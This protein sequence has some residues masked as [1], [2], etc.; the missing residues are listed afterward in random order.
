VTRLRSDSAWAE[1]PEGQGPRAGPRA[2]CRRNRTNMDAALT[3]R[4]VIA[5][6]TR[7]R[8][9]TGL[10]HGRAGS[11]GP[12]PPARLGGAGRRP[13]AF[14]LTCGTEHDRADGVG[15]RSHARRRIDCRC[16]GRC[17]PRRALAPARSGAGRIA[18]QWRRRSVVE[19][20]DAHGSLA[21]VLQQSDLSSLASLFLLLWSVTRTIVARYRA[22]IVWVSEFEHH[23]EDGGQ[24]AGHVVGAGHAPGRAQ[25]R[26]LRCLRSPGHRR[27]GAA[28]AGR[29]CRRAA[30]R[31][32][33][34]RG[35][36]VRR[37][38]PQIVA[39]R[40]PCAAVPRPRAGGRPPRIY[41]RPTRSR[42]SRTRTR[43]RRTNTA[44]SSGLSRSSNNRAAVDNESANSAACAGSSYGSVNSGSG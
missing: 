20:Q 14:R 13:A 31:R 28:A 17:L 1:P 5:A 15:N 21:P 26:C 41:R 6:R 11:A 35:R 4:A 27:Q 33:A 30:R 10:R 36:L 23:P 39:D 12:P 34:P 2:R 7:P 8:R 37:G 3:G 22:P 40:Y 42:R 44:R 43:P 24:H 9:R 19:L 16:P 18:D 29:R 32:T 38:R 25:A